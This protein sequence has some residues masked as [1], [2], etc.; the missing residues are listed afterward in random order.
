LAR[1]VTTA[2][3]ISR[4]RAR[5]DIRDVRH[6]D[7]QLK[8]WIDESYAELYDIMVSTNLDLFV[9]SDAVSVVSGTSSYSLPADWYK[10]VG[11]EVPSGGLTYN[12]PRFRWSDRHRLQSSGSNPTSM[13]YRIKGDNIYFKPTPNFSAT[14]TL[15]YVPAPSKIAGADGSFDGVSGWEKYIV[16]DVCVKAK[17][18]DEEDEKPFVRERELAKV[19]ITSMANDRDKNEPDMIQDTESETYAAHFSDLVG[20]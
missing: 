7:A 12:I 11:V 3:L 6:T 13:A 16:E 10:V 15:Y 14:V 9:T 20:L 4:I 5:G 17:M 8:D 2:A 1:S 19:R 18:A